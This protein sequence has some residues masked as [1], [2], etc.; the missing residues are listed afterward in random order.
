MSQK[1]L[2]VLVGPTASGK[3]ALSIAL[4]ERI[5][6]LGKPAE[7][8]NA[9][10]RQLYRFLD[11]GTAKVRSEEMQG[12]P[13]H[14]F[15]LKDPREDVTIAWYQQEA[16]RAIEDIQSRGAIPLLV[17]GSMLYVSAVIDGLQ[18]LPFD[19][20]LRAKLER[21]YA[22]LGAARLHRKL[23]DV[24]PDSAIGIDPKNKP[25]VV[26]ALEIALLTGD[27]PSTLKR[28]ERSPY[29][30]L[31][32]GIRWPREKLVERINIRTRQMIESG[33][34]EE[35]EGLLARGYRA[36]DPAMKSH[37]YREIVAAIASGHIDRGAL[38]EMISAKTRQYAKRQVT[39][40]KYDE[41][42][43]WIKGDDVACQP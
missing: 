6:A 5:G 22:E 7:I 31:I 12:I 20:G 26:R 15:D 35:V 21:E 38:A 40:W 19:S 10:S 36:S 24:D 2:I 14:L 4:A 16:L 13:H 41:R 11:I 33:W 25:Y 23:A 30:L 1:P 29:D 27:K 18:P 32:F 34:I 9:D 37:G 28:M 17:G 42:I 43:C 3:T 8:I 39:W